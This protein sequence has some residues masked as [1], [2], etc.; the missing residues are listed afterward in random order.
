MAWSTLD[1]E[2]SHVAAYVRSRV[3]S[4][5]SHLQVKKIRTVNS[6]LPFGFSCS[7]TTLING[8]EFMVLRGAMEVLRG[9]ATWVQIGLSGGS[10]DNL[11]VDFGSETG[12]DI[13]RLWF[14]DNFGDLFRE[15]QYGHAVAEYMTGGNKG[16]VI[17]PPSS[18][19]M[20]LIFVRRRNAGV[21]GE[22]KS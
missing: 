5:Y 3:S 15:Y 11:E 19:I 14:R 13:Y 7:L 21:D 6:D 18:D 2:V 17:R 8:N 12:L 10:S 4:P 1:R 20:N 9:C 16:V 22:S